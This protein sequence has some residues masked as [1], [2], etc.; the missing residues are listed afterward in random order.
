MMNATDREDGIQHDNTT[1]HNTH[2]IHNTL[3]QIH[4]KNNDYYKYAPRKYYNLLSNSNEMMVNGFIPL[5]HMIL[6]LDLYS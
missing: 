3:T 6:S 2:T 1:Q 4:Y 5:Q